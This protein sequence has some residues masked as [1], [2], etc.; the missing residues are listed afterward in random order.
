MVYNLDPISQVFHKLKHKSKL[1]YKKN[2][3]KHYNPNK[4]PFKSL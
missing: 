1:L 3:L 4:N 2:N